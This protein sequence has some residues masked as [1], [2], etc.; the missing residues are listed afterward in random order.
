MLYECL[1]GKEKNLLLALDKFKIY[2]LKD[3]REKNCSPVKM[4]VTSYFHFEEKRD[5]RRRKKKGEE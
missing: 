5:G 3:L 1:I 4:N 2:W